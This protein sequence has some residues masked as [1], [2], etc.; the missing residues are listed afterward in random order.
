MLGA[1]ELREALFQFADLRAENPGAPFNG[2]SDCLV[3]RLAEAAS[4]GLQIDKGNG[5]GQGYTRIL[6]ARSF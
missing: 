3:Q 1:G 2:G 4:L 6:E 5:R